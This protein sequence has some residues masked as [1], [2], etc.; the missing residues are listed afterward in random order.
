MPVNSAR[1]SAR[2]KACAIYS[3]VS[4][5]E[6]KP[7][8][9]LRQLRRFAKAQGWTVAA[10]Y[11][12]VETGATAK[13]PQFVAM[14][15]AAGRREFDIVLFWSLDRFSREGVGRTFRYLEQLQAAGVTWHNYRDPQTSGTGPYADLFIAISAVW[16]KVEREQ[17]SARTKAALDRAR[18]QGT[19][20]GRPPAEIDHSKLRKLR[21]KGLSVP[22]IARRLRASATTVARRIAQIAC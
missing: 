20:L 1:T 21:A 4:T 3:R 2:A 13:R 5:R 14:M 22:E 16:A 15:D 11:V 7:E 9:Q 19:R 10:E 17:I 18:E 6:Q 8:N 12:D